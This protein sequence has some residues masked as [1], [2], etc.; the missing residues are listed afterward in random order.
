MISV[1]Y[2]SRYQNIRRLGNQ[3]TCPSVDSRAEVKKY[4]TGCGSLSLPTKTSETRIVPKIEIEKIIN[5]I[6]IAT[7]NVRTLQDDVKLA[8]IVKATSK[9]DI[10]IIA[11]QETRRTG[12]G[13]IT[14][15][16]DSI[17]GWQ[18]IF[19]GKKKKHEHGV[20]LL[21]A[22]HVKIVEHQEIV[23]ARLLLANIVV[24]GM[25]L[26]VLNVYAPT[27]ST[28]AES[29]KTNFYRALDK[30]QLIMN[31]K[32]K[33]KRIVLGDFN[34]TISS[35][36]KESGAWDNIIGTNNSNLVDTNGNGEK[37][38]QMCQKHQLKIVNSFYR[39]KR[40]H[41]ATWRHASTGIWKR[42]DYICTSDWIMKFSKLCRVYTKASDQF[43]TDHRLLVL[44]LEFPASK[45]FLKYQN[46]RKISKEKKPRIDLFELKNDKGVQKCMT[47]KLDEA[48]ADND[49]DDVNKLNDIIVNA[50]RHGIEEVCPKTAERKKEEPWE[51]DE[52]KEM[53]QKLKNL[54]DHTQIRKQ[55]K[56]I[57]KYRSYL[58]NKY[59]GKLAD[60]INS[61]AEA[62]NVEKEFRLAKKYNILRTGS[63]LA[64]SNE[65]LKTH[66]EQHFSARSIPLPP[67][68]NESNNCTRIDEVTIPI[69]EGVPNED[70]VKNAIKSFKNNRCAGTDKLH[71]EGLKYNNSHNLINA[72]LKLMT[73]IW[74]LVSVPNEWLHCSITCLYK[75][76]VKSLASNYR[77]LS[78]GANM[79]RILAK[80]IIQRIKVAYEHY[81]GEEQYG[82]RHNRST[83]DAI[84]ITKNVIDRCGGTVIAIYIDLTAA[85]DHVP[86]DFL[87]RILKIRTG[88]YK[89]I[90]ILQKMYKGTTASIKGTKA[91]FDIL[92]GCRQGG[93]ESP[94]LFNLYF[95][96]VLKIAAH[97]IDKIYSDGWG[98]QYD[99]NIPHWCTNR[100]QRANGK[101]NG[102]DVIK[103]ILY[104]DDVVL[105]CKTVK[106]AEDLLNIINNTCNR[107]GLTISFKK[108]KTQVFNNDS[109]AN[110]ET[111]LKIGNEIIENVQEFTYL[112]LVI[113]NNNNADF[114]DHRTARATA[115]FNELRKI[116]TDRA[117][118]MKTRKKIL[119]S[120]V[121]SR[122]TYGTQAWFPN[123]QQLK[124]LES[125][126]MHCLRCIVKGGWKRKYSPE[127]IDDEENADYSFIFSNKKIEQIVGTKPL[128][129]FVN[130][131][132]L[133]Y[134]G[135]ICRQE[136]VRLTKKMF[137][138]KPTKS[139]F[140]DPWIKISK[141]LQI[142]IV[143][144]KR[145]TQSREKFAELVRNSTSSPL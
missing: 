48:L 37:M 11:L 101:M 6:R 143:Q 99:Y 18:L 130:Y 57:K 127:E 85:Y 121:R 26:S 118:N 13:E 108:T 42:L 110:N 98:I 50:V 23:A 39:S 135:H 102:K 62:R 72:I 73:L 84:F 137:F 138:A 114:T 86:R 12:Y 51:D 44:D 27:N 75:K 136:N 59:Y 133:K 91:I 97:E 144:A 66:F 65:R 69:N 24:K 113:H 117:V 139:Y 83:T 32:P 112:G 107:F 64:I 126:W 145:Q 15:E 22:P 87:F 38:L 45:R 1:Q 31:N 2:A 20:A 82:F 56:T 53:Y 61:L 33:F 78:I 119:E 41:R 90:A 104:A 5:K 68:L 35:R 28:K 125:C 92:T 71:T 123:E 3:G 7:I 88:A 95:D 8:M 141:L 79:S 96:Y 47:K 124:K 94:C 4:A 40:I 30:A 77:G 67:E 70:E 105:F 81:I 116:L 58:K 134:I 52:L 29:T 100:Q 115:K 120:C 46:S 140:R 49:S 131:Q 111:L 36:S 142:S 63:K 74:S 132:Y 19:S 21:L 103:W 34:A 93:Q 106:E 76:G 122:L 17:K 128:R 9:L 55:Q 10:D 129:D 54:K 43:D 16:D 109:L 89:L 25:R 14:F 80:I 60:E